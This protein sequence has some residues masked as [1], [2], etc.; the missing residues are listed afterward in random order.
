MIVQFT[1]GAEDISLKITIYITYEKLMYFGRLIDL[2]IFCDVFMDMLSKS[3]CSSIGG[4]E[5]FEDRDGI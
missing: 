1:I 5:I 3:F 4:S 2:A